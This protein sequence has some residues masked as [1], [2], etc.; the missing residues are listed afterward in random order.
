MSGG[1]IGITTAHELIHRNTKPMRGLGVFLLVLCC[2]GHFRTRAYLW[3]NHLNVAYLKKIP[4]A[5]ARRGEKF[6]FLFYSLCH[7]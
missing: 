3:S 6:L 4:M 2:Y 5:A 1:S 7:Q